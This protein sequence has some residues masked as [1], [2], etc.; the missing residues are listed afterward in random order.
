MQVTMPAAATLLL[1]LASTGLLDLKTTCFLG[2]FSPGFP[3]A[4]SL[5]TKWTGRAGLT[6]APR[7][8]PG[9]GCLAASLRRSRSPSRTSALGVFRAGASTFGFCVFFSLV[10]ALSHSHSRNS[11][12]SDWPVGFVL[13]FPQHLD[14]GPCLALRPGVPSPLAL[15]TIEPNHYPSF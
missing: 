12:F 6:F 7:W 14:F 11:A 4:W 15:H 1:A 10:R 8:A 2:D 13:A 5:P 9:W 3:R